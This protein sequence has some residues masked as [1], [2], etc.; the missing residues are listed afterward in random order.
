MNAIAFD[1]KLTVAV[2]GDF[3][4][5]LSDA[6]KLRGL[7]VPDLIRRELQGALVRERV[8]FR[9]FPDLER[10]TPRHRGAPMS[11]KD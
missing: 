8:P 9:G 4:R 3:R 1:H 5:A 2:P 11:R 7:S 6:A 10:P